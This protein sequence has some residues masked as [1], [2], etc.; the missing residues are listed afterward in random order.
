MSL[1]SIYLLLDRDT[2]LPFLGRAVAPQPLN[3]Y[4]PTGN[5]ITKNIKLYNGLNWVDI[6]PAST[7]P[8]PYCWN[9]HSNFALYDEALILSHFANQPISLSVFP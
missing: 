3:N 1:Y 8:T 9:A 5:L 7:D 4:T 6:T 2:Y